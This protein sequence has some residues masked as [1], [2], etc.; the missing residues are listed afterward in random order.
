MK[1]HLLLL[2][3][4]VYA[5][6]QNP[7]PFPN[8]LKTTKI[9]TYASGILP[10]NGG[11][12]VN[13]TTQAFVL[14]RMTTTQ[15]TAIVT[16]TTSALVYDT[17]L[18]KYQYWNGS[19]WVDFGGGSIPTFQEIYDSGLTDPTVITDGVNTLYL[20]PLIVQPITDLSAGGGA[21]IGIEDV[22]GANIN[23][24]LENIA[25]DIEAIV[26]ATNSLGG[27]AELKSTGKLKLKSNTGGIVEI[28]AD[29]VAT[30]YIAKLPNK[31]GTQTFAM[32]SDVGGGAVDSVN[33]QTG[34]VV[35]DADDI[36]DTSTTNKWTNAT[37]K[38][39]WNGKQATI[40][41]GASTIAS[42]NL[43]ASRALSSDAS[44]KVVVSAVTATEQGYLSGVTSAIQTQLNAKQDNP[45]VILNLTDYPTAASVT[46]LHVV[47]SHQILA[48]TL[49]NNSILK[50]MTCFDRTGTAGNSSMGIYLDT[51]PGTIG[52]AVSGTA[53]LIAAATTGTTGR[54]P[55]FERT[56]KL[57]SNLLT[58]Y[59]SGVNSPT[60]AIVAT[61]ALTSTPLTPST[62][63]Y[64]ITAVINNSA[65]DIITQRMTSLTQRK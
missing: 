59:P 10:I 2:L 30:N 61:S 24:V 33:G 42:A 14:P 8:G 31:T 1:K 57:A 36:S 52:S 19:A 45:N 48:N 29:D 17:T 9:D 56:F 64:L 5:F 4:S 62:T 21:V 13:S 32:L 20:T 18:G 60:D 12:T 25:G 40:T 53:Q 35:L 58:G 15:K 22:S 6:G 34:V 50:Y 11:V 26:S 16:P 28:N 63:Y 51:S 3:L 41:G 7:N 23:L 55:N 49:S 38:A 39:T 54:I 47:S 65:A 44:G 27:Y 46:T 37:E 43:T